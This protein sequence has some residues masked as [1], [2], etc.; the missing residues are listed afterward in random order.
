M[1]CLAGAQER[2]LGMTDDYQKWYARRQFEPHGYSNICRQSLVRHI[3]QEGAYSLT[4]PKRNGCSRDDCTT[5]SSHFTSAMIYKGKL[6]VEKAHRDA[7]ATHRNNQLHTRSNTPCQHTDGVELESK[8]ARVT[9]NDI[10]T[11]G[12]RFQR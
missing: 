5:V 12:G 8:Y 6:I 7:G 3:Q 1:R 2:V 4:I 10:V 9:L 11:L